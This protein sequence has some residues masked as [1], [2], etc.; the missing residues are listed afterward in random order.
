[1]AKPIVTL[2]ASSSYGS[3]IALALQGTSV[4]VNVHSVWKI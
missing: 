2:L 4:T 3:T 1:M